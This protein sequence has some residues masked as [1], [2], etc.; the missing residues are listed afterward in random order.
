M[1][2]GAVRIDG[3]DRTVSSG[4]IAAIELPP[5]EILDVQFGGRNALADPPCN[6]PERHIDD[7][8]HVTRGVQMRVELLPAPGGLEPLNE[9]RRRSDFNSAAASQVDS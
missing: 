5:D 1:R 2:I 3:D 7:L 4:H 9:I 6:L 8:T